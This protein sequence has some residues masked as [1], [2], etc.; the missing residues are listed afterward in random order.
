M[1]CLKAVE[2]GCDIIDTAISPLALGTSQPAT[3]VM[4]ETFKGTPY[5]T[6]LNQD[7]LAEINEYFGKIREEAMAS[8]LLNPKV[9]G[10]NINTLR[11]RFRAECF[12]T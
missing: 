10:V 7:I 1:S 3:E 9:L 8:G 12:Q 5:D 2:A 4:V 6:G 11:Y